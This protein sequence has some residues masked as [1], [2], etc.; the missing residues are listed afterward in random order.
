M[1][2]VT[3]NESDEIKAAKFL[4]GIALM[5]DEEY[6]DFFF[7]LIKEDHK[8]LIDT[9]ASQGDTKPQRSMNT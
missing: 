9:L 3:C 8:K 2:V 4:A 6:N 1:G 7:A 5:N